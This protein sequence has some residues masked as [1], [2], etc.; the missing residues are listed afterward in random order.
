MSQFSPSPDRTAFKPVFKPATWALFAFPAIG[1]MAAGSSALAAFVAANVA[2]ALALGDSAGPGQPAYDYVTAHFP[3][4]AFGFLTGYPLA[5]IACTTLVLAA[6]GLAVG[7]KWILAVLL[8]VMAT[9]T[10]WVTGLAFIGHLWS[11]PA[12]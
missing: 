8:L 6:T 12:A 7:R 5:F 4:S 11:L 3:G 1:G 2:G 10:P 9:A